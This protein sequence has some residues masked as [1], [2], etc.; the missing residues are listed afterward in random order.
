M[1][2]LGVNFAP[3]A[4]AAL[5]GSRNGQLSGVPQA[6]QILSLA[7]PRMLGV[8]SIA[9]SALL[10]AQGGQGMDPAASALFQTLMQT[11]TSHATRPQ[12]DGSGRATE[13][14]PFLGPRPLPGMP[15]LPGP[16]APN[17]GM[18]GRPTPGGVPGSGGGTG[19]GYGGGGWGGGFPGSGGGLPS[20]GSPRV[21]SDVDPDMPWGHR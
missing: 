7:L 2:N 16:G 17:T 5:S 9:P 13:M 10:H 12:G 11:L 21:V 19:G 4:D 8:R 1:D 20:V 18:P 3:T 14:S 15:T 6:I